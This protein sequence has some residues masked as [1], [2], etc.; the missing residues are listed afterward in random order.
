M[1]IFDHKNEL[2]AF[3]VY[4]IL[5]IHS[6]DTPM[7]IYLKYSKTIRDSAYLSQ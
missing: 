6:T 7:L 5:L 4:I 1:P 3:P 2:T